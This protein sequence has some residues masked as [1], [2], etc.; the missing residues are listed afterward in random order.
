MANDIELRK[1]DTG[2]AQPAW[3]SKIDLIKQT[4]AKGTTNQEL[5]MFLYQARR[6]GLDPLSRQIHCIVRFSTRNGQKERNLSIQTGIDGYRL[7][8]DHTGRYAGSDDYRFDEG[9][10][11]YEHIQTGRG[12]P[13][14]ATV[15]VH[16]I[17]QGQRVPF[18]A[19]CRWSEYYPGEKGGFQL[20]L[21]IYGASFSYPL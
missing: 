7:I 10:S 13:V 21:S 18:T 20:V 15:T 2:L 12:D 9:L 4:V 8:A 19:S 5:E 14:T 17:V 11:E 16:K 6:T 1:A 3:E